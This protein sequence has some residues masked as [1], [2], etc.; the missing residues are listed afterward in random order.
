MISPSLYKVLR[1]SIQVAVL[2]VFC[3]LPWVDSLEESRFALIS[4]SLFALD[5][6]GLPVRGAT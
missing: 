5:L 2:A 3:L 4:G 6:A 1:R